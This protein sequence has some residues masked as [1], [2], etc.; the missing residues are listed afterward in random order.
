MTKIIINNRASKNISL[1]KQMINNN[2]IKTR[3]DYARLVEADWDKH[4]NQE[5]NNDDIFKIK[6][7]FNANTFYENK[8]I[9]IISEDFNINDLKQAIPHDNLINFEEYNDYSN[10]DRDDQEILQYKEFKSNGIS[11]YEVSTDNMIVRE[12][13][14]FEKVIKNEYGDVELDYRQIYHLVNNDKLLD[15]KTI[16]YYETEDLIFTNPV[17]RTYNNLNPYTEA[18]LEYNLIPIKVKINDSAINYQYSMLESLDFSNQ[19]KRKELFSKGKSV[20]NVLI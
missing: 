20:I 9:M 7:K 14:T 11:Q 1:L 18:S 16:R 5:D 4:L 17:L 12:G 13:A 8:T 6:L 19:I 3:E 15:Y 10:Y 2:N